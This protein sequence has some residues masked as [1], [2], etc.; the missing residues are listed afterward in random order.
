MIIQKIPECVTED[1][2]KME[3]GTKLM[4][5]N[6][7]ADFMETFVFRK[8]HQY[9]MMLLPDVACCLSNTNLCWWDV[10]ILK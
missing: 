2:V 6:S 3:D 4:F 9:F 7:P 5:I 8:L 1:S 10:R